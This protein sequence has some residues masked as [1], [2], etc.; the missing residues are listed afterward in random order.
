MRNSS[1][2]SIL[3]MFHADTPVGPELPPPRDWQFREAVR[4]KFSCLLAEIERR[5]I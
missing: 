2:P 1:S 5:E 4:P 3:G